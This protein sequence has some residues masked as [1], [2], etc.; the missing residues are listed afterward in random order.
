[1]K[2]RLLLAVGLAS[3]FHAAQ[4]PARQISLAGEWRF[5]LDP[6]DKGIEERWQASELPE[7]IP[8]PGS[9][10]EHQRGTK[11]EKIESRRLT[12][13]W[14]YAGP[15]W[16]QRD[17]EIPAEWEGKR[18]FLFLER[19]H[20]ESQLWLDDGHVGL[21]N[22]LVAPHV[23]ELGL[24]VKPGKHRLTLRVDNRLKINVG[25][26][27]SAVTEEGPGNWNGVI[28][29]IELQM[30]EP[31]WIESMRVFPE[32][33]NKALR[34][35]LKIRNLTAK[36]AKSELTLR[37]AARG[38]ALPPAEVK[39][40]VEVSA[41]PESSVE[42]PL[43]LGDTV[44]LWDESTPALYDLSAS[45]GTGEIQ[46]VFGMRVWSRKGTQF[47]LNGRTIFLRGNVDNGAFPLKGYPAM[48]SEAWKQRLGIYRD[49][50]FN[51]VRFHSWCPPQ[52]A[53]A[54]ADELGMLLQIENPLWIGDGRVSADSARADFIRS[55]ANRIVDTYGN[56]P[57]FALMSMGNEL[58]DGLD[59]FLYDLVEQL[60]KKD[61]RR[62]YTSTSAP[63]NALRP[64]DYFVSAG[65]QG[66]RLRGDP[67]LEQNSP[68]T[69]FDY[70]EHLAGL[71]RPT[72][73]HEIGQW[74]VYPDLNEGRKYSG[75]QQPRYL[76]IYRQSAEKNN[77][78]GQLDA[79]RAASGQ[80][81]VSLY[82]EE[83]ESILRTPGIAGFQLLALAGW[84][85]F[86]PAF[87]G[88]LDPL[89]DSR[90]LITPASFR[91]FNN[92]TV[93]LLKMNK[94]EWTTAETFSAEVMV[95]DYSQ[96]IPGRGG[97]EW[98][99][100]SKTGQKIASGALPPSNTPVGG[101]RP[102][103]TIRLPLARLR[104]PAQ[105][106]IEVSAEGASND[107]D[108]WV[109][110]AKLPPAQTRG[111]L[112][113]RTWNDEARAALKSGRKVV[114]LAP[115][116]ELALT[117]PVSFTTTFWSLRWFPNRS[118]TMGILCDPKHPA[119]AAFPTDTHSNWQWWHMMSRARA[120]ILNDAP[121]ALRPI[122]QVIDDPTR[123]DRL[124]AVFEARIGKGKL[125]VSTFDLETSLDSRLAA[126]Q[127]R[128]SLL[129]YAA[130]NRF[131]PSEELD[132][133]FLDRLFTPEKRSPQ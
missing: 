28:G 128:D 109:Y 2:R 18:I 75:P 55:E 93:V 73:A 88:V 10:D 79:F 133:E 83:I 27:A 41:R 48:D 7:K 20:W 99:I 98:V 131:N 119:L 129:R 6:A 54:A 58:G 46:T 72:I 92:S 86:G 14:E 94:R 111:L 110:P 12:R 24:R 43:P 70:R 65:A 67:R 112:L 5:K 132:I 126:R 52:A 44:L 25:P 32:V 38:G 77:L 9:T 130:S 87:T 39:S 76:E 103:G 62:F 53:F 31:V 84:P 91:R 114:Y 35:Q 120:L 85:G 22:S 80:L 3:A 89:N 116:P 82:K 47:M 100:R 34:V 104:A 60:Q 40:Q 42:A 45:L 4:P 16:Y 61:P 23:H 81:M 115:A 8:L 121:A 51:H 117:V 29:R 57:S 124:G 107:W 105:Y 26:W 19:C 90:E 11:N 71:D 37:A 49:H 13:A 96:D 123:N 68:N 33:T 106:S 74:T 113:T 78:A 17:I 1:M 66:K 127:L 102:F 15:A 30:T 97:A 101:L 36:P 63:D 21:Q 122:V 69:D 108:F 125:L 95:A 50:G 59:P 64:D 56:H 118:E